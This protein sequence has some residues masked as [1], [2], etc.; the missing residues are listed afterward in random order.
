MT[1]CHPEEHGQPGWEEE[2]GQRRGI[3]GREMEP[4]TRSTMH[5]NVG[6]AQRPIAHALVSKA[7]SVK[8]QRKL[9]LVC[10]TVTLTVNAKLHGRE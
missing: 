2:E 10:E 9:Q 4:N 8:F 1:P 5:R 3:Q 6:H 7:G